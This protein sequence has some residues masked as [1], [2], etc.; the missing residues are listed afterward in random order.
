[1]IELIWVV[2]VVF[3]PDLVALSARSVGYI[4]SQGDVLGLGC[5]LM[6]VALILDVGDL[7]EGVDSVKFSG[8]AWGLFMIISE[9]FQRCCVYILRE[10]SVNI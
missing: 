3:W 5:I 2:S 4:G 6:R 10:L 8:A 7:R 1:M 9:V